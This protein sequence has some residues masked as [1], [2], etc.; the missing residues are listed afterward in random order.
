MNSV[1]PTDYPHCNEVRSLLSYQYMR[2]RQLPEAIM[3]LQNE[4]HG[5]LVLAGGTTL[6]RQL[7]QECVQ[8]SLLVDIKNIPELREIRIDA[9]S[10][11]RIGAAKTLTELVA[12]PG[13]QK[14]Y[15]LLAEACATEPSWQVRN[16]TTLGGIICV[17]CRQ[18]VVLAALLCY[19]ASVLL[20]DGEGE[21]VMRLGDFLREHYENAALSKAM[22]ISHITLA[23]RQRRFGTIFRG[24]YQKPGQRHPLVGVCLTGS[25]NDNAFQNVCVVISGVSPYL[26]RF[27]GIEQAL[28]AGAAGAPTLDRALAALDQEIQPV[29]TLQASAAYQRTMAAYLLSHCISALRKQLGGT[30]R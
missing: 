1:W 19:D 17:G 26:H 27:P 15:P 28:M 6:I 8:A 11:G 18:S 4:K 23:P 22:L 9:R 25:I 29:D 20:Q 16:R 7:R 13:V 10:G 21:R 3:A 14:Q 24:I 2:P 30:G 12:Y 5:A